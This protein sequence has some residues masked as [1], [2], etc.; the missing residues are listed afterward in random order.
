MKFLIIKSPVRA[1]ALSFPR[2]RRLMIIPI[3]RA[4]LAASR[5]ASE[6]GDAVNSFIEKERYTYALGKSEQK[7]SIKFRL[8][9]PIARPLDI[10]IISLCDRYAKLIDSIRLFVSLLNVYRPDYGITTF[11]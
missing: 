7:Y 8:Q 5:E 4:N 1:R 6:Y 2:C 11:K 3:G 9:L 10:P